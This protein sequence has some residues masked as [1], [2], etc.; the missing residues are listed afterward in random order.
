MS[1]TIREMIR[2][3]AAR[4]KTPPRKEQEKAARRPTV[5]RRRIAPARPKSAPSS[6]AAP[7]SYGITTCS[8]TAPGD[9]LPVPPSGSGVGTGVWG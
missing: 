2:A 4:H 8:P 6:F 1:D 7:D 3:A 5:H 9:P